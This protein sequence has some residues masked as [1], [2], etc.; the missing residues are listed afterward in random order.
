MMQRVVAI[1]VWFRVK[2]NKRATHVVRC[3]NAVF[4]CV[5]VCARSC[6]VEAW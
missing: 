3:R 6:A 1:V 2:F 5:C 4:V